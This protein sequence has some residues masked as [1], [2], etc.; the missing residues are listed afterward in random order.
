[1]LLRIQNEMQQLIETQAAQEELVV[2]LAHFY[3]HGPEGQGQAQGQGARAAQAES[4]P[5]AWT[6]ATWT[7]AWTDAWS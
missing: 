2:R 6:D 5:D 1:M 7:D 4:E 3:V